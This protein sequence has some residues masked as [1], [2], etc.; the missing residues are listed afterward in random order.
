M[1]DKHIYEFGQFRIDPDER[2][3]LRDGKPVPLTPKAFETLLALVE[4]SG[5]VIKKDDLMMR[6]WPDAIV[7]EVNLAKNVSTVRQA[8]ETNGEQY[9]ETVPKLG[10]RLIVRARMVEGPEHHAKA[11]TQAAAVAPA[12]HS[13]QPAA[14]L[15]GAE[16][17]AK[18]KQAIVIGLAALALIGLSVAAWRLRLRQGETAPIHSLV[19]LPLTNLSGDANQEYFADGLTEALITDVAKVAKAEPLRVISR[20]TAMRYKNTSQAVPQ[21]ARELQVDAVLEGAVMRSG[22]HVRITA[23]LIRA[24]TDE[25]IWAQSYDRNLVDALAVQAEIAQDIAKQINLQI[26]PEEAQKAKRSSPSV[27]AQDLYLRARYEWNKRTPQSLLRARTLFQ[28]ALDNDPSYAL[29]W[30]GFANTE[31]L[32]SQNGYEIVSP[33]EGMPRA[34][35]AARRALELDDHLGEAH[36][37]LGMVLWAYEWNWPAA[38]R[39]YQRALELNPSD[40]SLHEFYGIAL[41]S[42]GHFDQAIAEQ[43]RAVEL[44]PLSPIIRLEVARML[45]F[46]RRYDEAA[47]ALRKVTQLE[48]DFFPG[49]EMLGMVAMSAGHNDEAIRE[50]LRARQLAPDSTWA[51]MNLIRAC[52]RSGRRQEALARREELRHLAKQKYVPAYQFAVISAELGEMDAAF[53][54]L[55]KAFDEPSAVMMLIK[56]E[57]IFD[58]LRGDPRFMAFVKRLGPR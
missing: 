23:Q 20:T 44:D 29:A 51:L 50:L 24:A 2:L 5:H 46:A 57:P 33:V 47:M 11:E 31:Y 22:D 21:I 55:E 1:S 38:E 9:I 52:A 42:Q 32:L 15:A 41:A 27:E 17:A 43:K 37:S 48:P 53:Q 13:T 12:V 49:H 3:L 7:E 25:H 35:A 40:A 4:N 26:E 54:W 16:S 56:V 19:I 18:K 39:E 28:Q 58:S 30:V 14:V 34:E 10:Y 8:I 45:Y 6:V 36:G